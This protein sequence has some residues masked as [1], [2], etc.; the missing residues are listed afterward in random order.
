MAGTDKTQAAIL[1]GPT[2]IL[3]EPQLGENIG[4]TARAML[5]FGLTDLRIVNPRDGWP[6]EATRA[7]ASGADVV[8]DGVRVYDRTE[9]AIADLSVVYAA[10]ARRR[11]MHLPEVP[12][13]TAA[14][15]M[16][17]VS[18]TGEKFGVLFGG[19]RWGLNNDDVSLAQS[20][21]TVPVNPA[22]SSLNLAQSVLLVAYEWFQSGLAEEDR[23]PAPQIV[24]PGQPLADGKAMD[25]FFNH[26]ESELDAAGFLFPPEKRPSVTRKLRNFFQRARPRDNEVRMLRGVIAAL[27]EFGGPNQRRRPKK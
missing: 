16:R 26:L 24:E 22:F 4:T 8:I 9:E 23:M 14:A 18:E 20:V 6:N 27:V 10:T 5:N 21:L 3:V 25:S 13:R 11:D 17:R 2:I 7:S 1:G 15:E 19:E 12:P